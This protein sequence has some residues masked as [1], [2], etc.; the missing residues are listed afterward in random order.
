[1]NDFDKVANMVFD[2]LIKWWANW[3]IPAALFFTFIW[4][5]FT[6]DNPNEHRCENA[7]EEI[8]L[9]DRCDTYTSCE[10]DMAD[11]D[12]RVRYEKMLERC[13]V[14]KEEQK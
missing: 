8:A 1:M 10:T 12:R 6:L 4:F 14:W 13:A 2:F 7:A 3:T 9:L 11:I 5:I